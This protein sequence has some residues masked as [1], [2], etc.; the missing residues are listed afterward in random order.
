MVVVVVVMVVGWQLRE[1]LEWSCSVKGVTTGPSWV[2]VLPFHPCWGMLV[3]RGHDC[4]VGWQGL[5]V[6][7][8]AGG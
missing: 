1:G 7:R 4:G 6:G 3:L 5:R 2:N 8:D